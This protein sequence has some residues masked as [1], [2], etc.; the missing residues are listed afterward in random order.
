MSPC[1]P[2]THD[3]SSTRPRCG[4]DDAKKERKKPRNRWRKPLD[5]TAGAALIHHPSQMWRRHSGTAHQTHHQKKRVR[6]TDKSR[7]EK[8]SPK[9]TVEDTRLPGPLSLDPVHPLLGTSDLCLPRLAIHLCDSSTPS[10]FRRRLRRY[11]MLHTT[12]C[13]AAY[14]NA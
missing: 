6:P 2:S 8:G 7:H 4:C 5:S 12:Y 1:R 9:T 3:V 10:A 13:S 11:V 14:G